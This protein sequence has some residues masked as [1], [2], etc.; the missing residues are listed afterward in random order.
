MF[1]VVAQDPALE[2]RIVSTVPAGSG[3]AEIRETHL[4]ASGTGLLAARAIRRLGGAVQ[5]VSYAGGRTGR[6]LQSVLEQ[7]GLDGT[8][9][10][11][12]APTPCHVSVFSPDEGDG[13]CR[14]FRQPSPALLPYDVA[15]LVDLVGE[16]LPDATCV[17]LGGTAPNP[18]GAS[19]FAEIVGRAAAAGVPVVMDSSAA[20]LRQAIAAG[21]CWVRVS[22]DAQAH[23]AEELEEFGTRA[24]CA[25]IT[26]NGARPVLVR[27][28]DLRA[29][30]DPPDIA[31][32][33]RGGAG[34]AMLAGLAVAR[35]KGRDLMTSVR[36]AIAV[37]V[38]DLV[39]WEPCAFSIDEPE[40]FLGQVHQCSP[41]RV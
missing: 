39:R 11:V 14:E 19:L 32:R 23:A 17:V 21:P 27:A 36:Y 2:R 38:A 31:A 16:A 33:P 34:S 13:V 18:S 41:L 37:A 30:F 1:L 4:A 24:D 25:V 22:Q 5:L 26:T 10:P 28:A 29:A 35:A 40:S 6:V 3:R 8:L 20:C 12:S 9:L 7:E 15:D